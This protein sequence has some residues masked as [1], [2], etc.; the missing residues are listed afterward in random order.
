[1][2][3][4]LDRWVPC[5]HAAWS[6]HRHEHESRWPLSLGRIPQQFAT[7][8]NSCLTSPLIR[9]Y[10]DEGTASSTLHLR[11]GYVSASRTDNFLFALNRSDIVIKSFKGYVDGAV[12]GQ[13]N[14]LSAPS[15]RTQINT[16]QELEKA[17]LLSKAIDI[18]Y[19]E[20]D[21]RL[22]AGKFAECDALLS[23]LDPAALSI[24][25][26][27]GLLSITLAASPK[28][29]NRAKFFEAARREIESRGKDP[30]RLLDGLRGGRAAHEK[31]VPAGEN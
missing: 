8:V 10:G 4:T 3:P 18:I 9:L 12:V 25:I 5:D 14:P 11:S 23:T 22:R 19:R 27:F 31:G 26:I 28:L 2:T 29:K 17:G 1:M 7:S 20:V 24:H 6:F 16:A 21:G 13:C 30:V 15:L